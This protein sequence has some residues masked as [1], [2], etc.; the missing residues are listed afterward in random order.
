MLTTEFR[1]TTTMERHSLLSSKLK[2][3]TDS[4]HRRKSLLNEIELVAK[5]HH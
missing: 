2:I 3:Q 5:R 4:F 1:Q